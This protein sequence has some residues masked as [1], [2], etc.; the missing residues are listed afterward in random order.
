MVDAHSV[1][2]SSY[3]QR[4]NM[5]IGR[6]ISREI[7][8]HLPSD[9]PSAVRGR[10]DLRT[11]NSLMGNVRWIRKVLWRRQSDEVGRLFD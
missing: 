11:I 6:V 7:L 5:A 4:R 3:V 2:P 9:D 8:D 10:L 1:N